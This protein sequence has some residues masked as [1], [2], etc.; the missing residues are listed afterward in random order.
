MRK[1]AFLVLPLCC[2]LALQA[3]AQS[4][5]SKMPYQVE[6]DAA[7]DVTQMDRSPDGKEG[8]FIK[9]RFAITLDGAKVE[10][11]GDDHKLVIEENGQRVKEVDVPRPVASEELSVM[12][13]IDTSGSMKEH[14]RMEQARVAAD[15]FL[16]KLPVR[17]DCGLIL[18]DHEIRDKV[19]PIFPRP[20]LLAKINEVQPRGGTAYLDAASEG[21]T[22]LRNT[23]RGRDRAVVLMTD[24]IDLNS[25]KSIQQVI[26]EAKRDHV[27]VYTIGI[28]EPGKLDR[29]N[30]VLVLDHSGSMKTPAS[31]T[32]TATKIVALHL[33]AE[34][35][36]DSM[37]TVG[38]VSIIP[39]SSLVGAPRPFLDKS[40]AF[41]LKKTIKGLQAYGETALFDAT[42]EAINVLE[43]DAS[44]G[45]RAVVTMTDGFDN[46]SRRRVDEVIERAKDAKIPLYMLAFGRDNE[47]D[48]ATMR[49]MAESTGGK[50]Y[51]AK[52]KDSLIEIFENLSIQLHD[53]GIDETALKQLAGETGGQYYPAKNVTELKIILEQVTKNIQ[54]ESYQV[55]FP[56]LSQRAD[57][58]QRNVTLKLVQRSATGAG[59]KV[60]EEKHGSYQLRGLVVAEMNHFVYLAL[61]VVIGGLIALPSLLRRA[62]AQ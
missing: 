40:Q 34:R 31:D 14:R 53:D 19:P 56:S 52:N 48:A 20:P 54:R 28:G 62:T 6:F 15:A 1:L 13:A 21:I 5:K 61:L 2:L 55:V 51:H 45:K 4:K 3:P 38:R 49:Q 35:F 12:L 42:L 27:R 60:L 16:Q 33:A 47:I 44:R 50:F 26:A 58:T 24:G 23:V 46:T 30:S 37:S 22:V 10:K 57:G 36:V 59:D 39:F 8:I 32:D 25:K 11:F 29:V 9:V 43:A 18:F 7:K 41:T 17:S